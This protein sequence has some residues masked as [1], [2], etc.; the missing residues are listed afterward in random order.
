MTIDHN[1]QV[2]EFVFH[3]VFSMIFNYFAHMPMATTLQSVYVM[4]C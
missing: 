4:L 1:W 3:L 2:K